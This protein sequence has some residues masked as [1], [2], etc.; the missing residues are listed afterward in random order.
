MRTLL[1]SDDVHAREAVDLFVFRLAREAGAMVSSLGG[2]DG[3]VFSAGIGEHA[4]AIRAR[5]CARLAWL[6]IRVDDAANAR[7]AALISTPDSRVQV[8][9]IA[10]DEEAMIASHTRTLDVNAGFTP[11]RHTNDQPPHRHATT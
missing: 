7:N 9:V 4:P 11:G 3:L 5:V 8:R 6:G 10:T 2:L 1:D